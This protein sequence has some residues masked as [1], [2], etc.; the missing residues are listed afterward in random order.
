MKRKFRLTKSADYKRV[1]RTGK[2][3]AHPLIVLII[4]P[5]DLDYPQIAVS[6]S[7]SMGNAVIRNRAKRRI[8]ACLQSIMNRIKPG[9]NLVFI[10]RRPIR[11]SNFRQLNDAIMELLIKTDLL[12]ELDGNQRILNE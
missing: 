12:S 2:S 10:A 6:V 1:R 7:R 3:F 5:N 11:Y 9:W 8:R 4:L